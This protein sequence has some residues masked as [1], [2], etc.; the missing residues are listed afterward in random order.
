H[1]FKLSAAEFSAMDWPIE[2]LGP[3]AIV[4]AGQAKR[5]RAREAIQ[6][7]SGKP[8]ERH[9]YAHTGWRQV[10]GDQVYLH[11]GGA[12]GATNTIAT[13]MVLPEAL[14]AF[15]LPEAPAG[16]RLREV[17]CASMRTVEIAPAHVTVPLYG[18][19]WRPI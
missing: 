10:D 4:Y 16:E 6:L 2:Q 18:L 11:G 13:E 19:I 8:A 17:V 1:R 9:S 15:V 7:L 3:D 14:R 12:I 5:D